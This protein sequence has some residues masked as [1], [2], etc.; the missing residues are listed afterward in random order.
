MTSWRCIPQLVLVFTGGTNRTRH[1]CLTR[2]VGSY[3]P[4][5]ESSRMQRGQ[6]ALSSEC[7][8]SKKKK[9]KYNKRLNSSQFKLLYCFHWTAVTK[10]LHQM[11]D[12]K[13]SYKSLV[14]Q[15][16][17]D[18]FFFFSLLF[19][20]QLAFIKIFTFFILENNYLRKKCLFASK[21]NYFFKK[22][23]LLFVDKN[24]INKRLL[25]FHEK[26]ASATKCLKDL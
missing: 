18:V 22:I 17:I 16:L 12:W 3:G 15:H 23:F 11:G 25:G 19:F 8:W 1:N 21:E 4:L 9:A 7:M 24:N 2:A 14:F 13:T 26:T 5:S 20:N 6:L 10:A